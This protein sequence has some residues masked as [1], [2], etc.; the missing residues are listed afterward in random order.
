M[1]TVANTQATSDYLEYCRTHGLVRH[2]ARMPNSLAEFF[3][4]FLTE[5]GDMVVDPFAGSNTT[6]AVSERLGRQWMAIE[7]DKEY[8]AGSRGRFVDEAILKREV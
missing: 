7:A 5:T 6:G 8:V 1:I 4:K 2:P 3:V